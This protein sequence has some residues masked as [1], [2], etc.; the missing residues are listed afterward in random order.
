VV[1][2]S[3]EQ[4]VKELQVQIRFLQLL[5]QGVEVVVKVLIHLVYQEVAVVAVVKIPVQ[6]AVRQIRPDRELNQHSLNRQ[7]AQIT[8]IRVSSEVITAHLVEAGVVV[9]VPLE[10]QLLE[11]Q[12]DR[13]AL[14]FQIVSRALQ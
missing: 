5:L 10:L 13:V 3:L 1:L 6:E 4:P 2:G 9:Q 11:I 7:I 8:V 14:E 12:V